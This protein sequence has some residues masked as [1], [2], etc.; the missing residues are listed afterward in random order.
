MAPKGKFSEELVQRGLAA[1]EE[2]GRDC[3]AIGVMGVHRATYYEWLNDPDKAD[4]REAVT[5][6][7]AKADFVASGW[8]TLRR[9]AQ[10]AIMTHLESVGKNKIIHTVK[11]VTDPEGR[12]TRTEETK[13]M[14]VEPIPAII[15]LALEGGQNSREAY[16]AGQN[17][18]GYI[19]GVTPE[20]LG[21]RER[22]VS[23]RFR[24]GLGLN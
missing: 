6:A 9:L 23:E 8:P 5:K 22:T 2:T 14:P 20:D 12:V 21:V 13:T 24:E 15:A 3:D 7:K 1:L 16:L 4:F 10:A 19:E 11:E 17:L 18:G